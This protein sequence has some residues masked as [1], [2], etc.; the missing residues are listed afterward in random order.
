MHFYLQLLSI[1]LLF[2]LEQYFVQ[3]TNL[4]LTGRTDLATAPFYLTCDVFSINLP[5]LTG[6]SDDSSCFNSTK[7]VYSLKK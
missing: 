1:H 7:S 5:R 4:G 3:L 2:H 6:T